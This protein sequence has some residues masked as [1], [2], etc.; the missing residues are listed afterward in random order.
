MKETLKIK[1]YPDGRIT[2]TENPVQEVPLEP[3]ECGVH[4]FLGLYSLDF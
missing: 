2:D 1:K 3:G 4:E